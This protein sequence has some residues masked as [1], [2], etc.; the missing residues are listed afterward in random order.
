MRVYSTEEKAIE[1]LDAAAKVMGEFS[2]YQVE[3]NF[4]I[5][6]TGQYVIACYSSQGNF[7]GFF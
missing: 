2:H 7:N 4:N 5:L 3:R 1:D 6:Y